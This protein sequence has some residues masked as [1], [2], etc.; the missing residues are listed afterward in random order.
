MRI[1]VITS[2][3]PRFEG[4]GT[5]PFVRS[6]ST[7]LYRKGHDIQLAAPYDI[8]VDKSQIDPFPVQRFKYILPLKFHI[9]GH[10]R[11]LQ[12]DTKL[13]FATYLLLPLYITSGL[14]CLLKIIIQ[15]K[16]DVIHAHWLL[17]NGLIALIASKLTRTPFILSLHGSDIFVTYKNKWFKWI[18]KTI[19]KHSS[20][21]SACSKELLDRATALGG[22]GKVRIISWGAD[23]EKF[24]PLE[25]KE[26]IRKFYGWNRD[27]IVVCSLGRMVPKKG[28]ENLLLS[29]SA[30]TNDGKKIKLAIGGDGPVREQLINLATIKEVNDKLS[31]PGSIPWNEVGNFL[32]AADI[33]VLPSVRDESGNLDGLPT[34]LLEAMACGLPCIASNIGGVNLVIKNNENGKLIEPNNQDSLTNALQDL[35]QNKE[36]R[37]KIS[38]NARKSIQKEFNWNR[39]ADD[40]IQIIRTVVASSEKKRLG[41]LF[42]IKSL[43]FLLEEDNASKILDLGCH[44]ADWLMTKD[45]PIKVGVDFDPIL[46]MP[47]IPIVKA[48]VYRLPF[49]SE[50]FDSIYA[51]DLIEHLNDVQLLVKEITRVLNMNGKVI[52][53]TPSNEIRI[54]PKILTNI[55]SHAWGHKIR[56]GFTKAEIYELFGKEFNITIK[57][58]SAKS[59]LRNYVVIRTIQMINERLALKLLDSVVKQDLINPWGTHGFLL[60]LAQRKLKQDE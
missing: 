47:V 59:Y 58:W 51:L 11:S 15:Q 16:S 38:L 9:M 2:S 32:G 6:L 33:F 27:E 57:D 56:R 20:A 42:R 49:K 22:N 36:L 10:A 53:S 1:A 25:N 23:P 3:Y 48:D 52:I 35:I 17:P 28:F 19:L 18:G 46:L 55:I 44:N 14:I 50:S 21:V 5:A 45:A 40:F 29:F 43:P 60:I 41:Q 37:T 12:A 8:E 30:F 4:D 26:E 7:A 34:V 24:K 54:H 13:K 39:V 31:L